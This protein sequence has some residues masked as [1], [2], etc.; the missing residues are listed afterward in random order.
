M[1]FYQ[2]FLIVLILLG[3]A[4]TV[5]MVIAFITGAPWVPTT[6]HGIDRMIKEAQL[7]PG[8]VILD[9]GCGDAR[10]LFRALKN[11][12]GVTAIGYELF[13][14]PYMFA[15]VHSLFNND[16]SIYFQDSRKVDMSHVDTLFCYMMPDTLIKLGAIWKKKLPP[17]AQVISYAFKIKDWECARKIE[18]V[19]SRNQAPI[20]IYRLADQQ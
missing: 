16:V 7:K 9:P 6:R 11:T 12:S 1:V 20:Y 5:P 13:F 3:I 8:D 14:L 10:I 18:K 19:P 4:L 15:K 17:H 2:L